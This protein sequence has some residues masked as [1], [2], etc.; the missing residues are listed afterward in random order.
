MLNA[1]HETTANLE[2][3]LVLKAKGAIAATGSVIFFEKIP[4]LKQLME[5]SSITI[6]L[7]KEPIVEFP[8]DAE[9]LIGTNEN[10][11]IMTGASRTADIEKKIIK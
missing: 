6:M 3:G 8:S 4:F 11:L 5:A 2:K 7:D 9:N 10:A 1:G